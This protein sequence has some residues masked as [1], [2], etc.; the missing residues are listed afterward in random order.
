MDSTVLKESYTISGGTVKLSDVDIST[1]IVF[2]LAPIEFHE[3]LWYPTSGVWYSV[4]YSI[5]P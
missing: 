4:E 5:F 2:S 3:T 1:L